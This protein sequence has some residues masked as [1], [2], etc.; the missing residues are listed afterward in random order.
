MARVISL[1]HSLGRFTAL[2]AVVVL[3]DR[4]GSLALRAAHGLR[5]TFIAWAET[6]GRRAAGRKLRALP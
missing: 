6:R 4:S 5:M 2:G 1:T 3:L